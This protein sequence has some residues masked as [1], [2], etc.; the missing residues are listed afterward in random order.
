MNK[1]LLAGAL[2]AATLSPVAAQAQDH[3]HD[4]GHREWR[5]ERRDDRRDWRQDHRGWRHD[6]RDMRHN[7]HHWRA[8]FAYRS[9]GVGVVAPRAYW[10]QNYYYNDWRAHRL[11]RP[12]RAYYRY[13]R[14]YGD[15]LL[16]NTR[17]GR[18]VSVQ[19][20]YFR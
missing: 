4:R 1:K 13:V 11:Q 2:M 5:D 3:H 12:Q 9:F 8:P 20:N 7:G 17:N 14:H 19:R 6:R 18:V 10:G 16:I 15:L